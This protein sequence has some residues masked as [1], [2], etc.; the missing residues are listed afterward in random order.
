MFRITHDP[1][2][3]SI[4]LYLIEITYDGSHAYYVHNRCLV[5][6]SGL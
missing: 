3:G 1:S 6:Y 4:S 5:A 2:S